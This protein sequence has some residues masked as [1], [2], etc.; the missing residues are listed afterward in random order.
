MQKNICTNL[1]KTTL[2]DLLTADRRQITAGDAESLRGV[3]CVGAQVN[4]PLIDGIRTEGPHQEPT[5]DYPL[6]LD[7]PPNVM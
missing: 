5:H 6:S 7:P 1:I 4:L 3:W 2:H